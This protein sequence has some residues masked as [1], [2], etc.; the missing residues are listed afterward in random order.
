MLRQ[1]Y[2]TRSEYT[3]FAPSTHNSSL[4]KNLWF[5]R[6]EREYAARDRLAHHGFQ[7]RQKI[8]LYGSSVMSRHYCPIV[9]R[10]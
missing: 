3:Y 7:Y 10:L 8:L 4:S 1:T 6:I 2:I 5:Q 9:I